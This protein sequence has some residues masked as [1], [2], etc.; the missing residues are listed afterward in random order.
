MYQHHFFQT[1]GLSVKFHFLKIV[2]NILYD[3]HESN[4]L[5]ILQCHILNKSQMYY[6]D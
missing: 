3:Y 5:Y 6:D 4:E 2:Q 1:Y